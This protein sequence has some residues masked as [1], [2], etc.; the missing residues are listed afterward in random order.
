LIVASTPRGKR[1]FFWDIW[2]TQGE[3]WAKFSVT[4]DQCPRI[5]KDFLDQQLELLGQ[6]WFEQEYFC[7]FLEISGT[8]FSDD[9]INAIFTDDGFV[10]DPGAFKFE[11]KEEEV[12]WQNAFGVGS[13]RN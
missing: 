7:R 11:L 5:S 12:G 13:E 8:L 2:K 1:G 3:Q 4:A 9:I 6:E 10:I